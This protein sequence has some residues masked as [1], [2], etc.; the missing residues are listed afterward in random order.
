MAAVRQFVAESGY[1][2]ALRARM[3]GDASTRSYERLALGDKHVILMNS[4]RRPDGPPVR[5]GKPYSAIAHLAESVVPFV[6]MAD[7]L[8]RYGFSAPAIH[9][10]D[11]D[12]G[13]LIIEDLGDERVVAGD[14]PAPNRERYEAAV[15]VL[16]ALHAQHLPDV[17]PVAPHVDYRIPHYDMD[18]FL[19][20]AELL[21]D[22]YLPRLDAPV[23]DTSAPRSG[24]SGASSCSRRSM[25]RRPGCC[26]TSTRPTCSG[27]R[28]AATS[29]ASASSISR[30]P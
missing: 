8:R 30:T 28:R 10:A 25:R 1:S 6:A 22:W 2:D 9:H 14:P 16:L 23:P 5:D 12:Q 20:E 26:A 11:L 29:P 24:R 18:A 3:Q 21:L 13:L 7:G 19:I 27:C 15:D 4:P 17:L